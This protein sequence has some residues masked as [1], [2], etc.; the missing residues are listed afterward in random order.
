MQ[1]V[2]CSDG[3]T[4]A[5]GMWVMQRVQCGDGY[6]VAASDDGELLLWGRRSKSSA[7]NDDC[8]SPTV[9]A[10]VTVADAD[11]CRHF[12]VCSPTQLM[13]DSVKLKGHCRKPSNTS[14]SSGAGADAAADAGTDDTSASKNTGIN[15]ENI[16]YL[17]C[18]VTAKTLLGHP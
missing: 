6:T 8:L 1:R 7:S 17:K 2:Q 9:N 16:F 18:A 13:V 5:C 10:D 12:D 15:A 14:I 3:Y 11:T 4:V